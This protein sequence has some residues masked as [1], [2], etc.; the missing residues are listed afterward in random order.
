[1]TIVLMG[2]TAV[3]LTVIL[4]TRDDTAICEWSGG[5]KSCCYCCCCCFGGGGVVQGGWEKPT[6]GLCV[7]LH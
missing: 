5:N 3:P 4:D 7:E 6:P 1:M 2:L